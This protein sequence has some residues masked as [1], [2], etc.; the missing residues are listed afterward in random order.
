MSFNFYT[1]NSRNGLSANDNN[2]LLHDAFGV[3]YIVYHDELNLVPSNEEREI[4]DRFDFMDPTYIF[5][6]EEEKARPTRPVGT[7][8]LTKYTEEEGLPILER[9]YDEVLRRESEI[10]DR[11]RDGRYFAEPS[12]FTVLKDHRH[13]KT[14]VPSAL[15]TMM[16]ERCIEDGV[17][18]LIMVANPKQIELYEKAGFR[19][20][21]TKKD[22]LT[23]MESPV[24]HTDIERG[25]KSDFGRFV[26]KLKFNMAIRN[27]PSISQDY[28]S[29]V[30]MIYL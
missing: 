4:Y 18:D 30:S 3:R 23:G 15:T 6:A 14:Y 21:G 28:V 5:L 24:M 19:T 10:F 27:L 11:I 12:R 13:G 17:T 29:R 1:L 26:K 8:R 9:S 22:N 7:M 20:L 2:S 25:G 16:Y